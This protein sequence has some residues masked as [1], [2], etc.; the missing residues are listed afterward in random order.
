M[1]L[2]HR[3]VSQAAALGAEGRP[4]SALLLLC[5]PPLALGGLMCLNVHLTSSLLLYPQHHCGALK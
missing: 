3:G 1:Q 2:L 4:L 5:P